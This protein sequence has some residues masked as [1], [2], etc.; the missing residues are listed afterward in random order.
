MSTEDE[1]P[2]RGHKL[3]QRLHEVI[4]EADTPAGRWFDI[5]L[6]IFI[7][8]SV[9]I[10]ILES[11]PSLDSRYHMAFKATEW[12]FT[13]FFTIE[14]ALRLYSTYKPRKYALSFFGVID[15]LS[16]L[17]T[18]LSLIIAGTHSLMVIR[19]LR[20]LRVFRILKLANFTRQGR[21]IM[22]ALVSSLPKI[23]VFLVF[24]LVLVMIFGSIM[25]LIE[26]GTNANFDSIPRS[27]YWAI[28]TLTT[29]G[30]GDITPNTNLGQ[31]LAA[32]IMILGYAV[33][34]VPT[35]IISSDLIRQT[36][37]DMRI[38]VNTQLCQYC[39][40]KGHAD[41]AQFCKYCSKPLNA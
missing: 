17:P 1:L 12:I 14:Y 8:A 31:A 18:Y 22:A 41:D 23:L 11:V 5:I 6:L 36:S 33:I 24:I 21:I 2:K 40:K 10:V 20:L 16:I 29:V 19:A 39:G 26:G 30:Y 35:G 28:V 27:I 37:R 9:L 15:L 25:Y 13:I 34:A 4:T 3:R 32:F 38:E 7:M